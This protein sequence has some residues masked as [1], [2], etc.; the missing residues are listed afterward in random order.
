MKTVVTHLITFALW[1]QAITIPVV[2]AQGM[3]SGLSFNFNEQSAV[4]AEINSNISLDPTGED[5]YGD[6]SEEEMALLLATEQ[7]AQNRAD[8]DDGKGGIEVGIID[9]VRLIPVEGQADTYEE[10]P[11]KVDCNQVALL[12]YKLLEE[13]LGSDK[14]FECT[15]KNWYLDEQVKFAKELELP[16]EK[17]FCKENLSEAEK[18]RSLASKAMEC[19]GSVACNMLKTPV[20]E[21]IGFDPLADVVKWATQGS[22]FGKGCKDT[23]GN[24]CI[25]T[26]IWGIFK[27]LFTNIEGFWDLGKMLVNGVVE[28]AKWVGGKVVEAG[29][30]VAEKGAGIINWWGD[31]LFGSKP[32][33]EF[34]NRMASRHDVISQQEDG[35]FK[36]FLS[37]PLGT[38][39][40]LLSSLFTGMMDMIV[41]GTKDNF[42]CGGDWYTQKGDLRSANSAA[43]Y[44]SQENREYKSMG[45]RAMEDI[46]NFGGDVNAARHDKIRCDDPFIAECASCGQWMNMVC[47]LAGFLGGEVLTAVL[48]GGAV[49]VIGKGAK[50]ASTGGRLVTAALRSSNKW[51]EF[52]KLGKAAAAKTKGAAFKGLDNLK[53]V[54]KGGTE[55]LSKFSFNGM[56]S[57]LGKAGKEFVFSLGGK[58]IK[59]PGNAKNALLAALKKGREMGVKGM[60]KATLKAPFKVA[61]KT[62]KMGYVASKSYLKL[63]DDAFIYG[64]QGKKGLQIARMAKESNRIQKELKG[65]K[66][67]AEAGDEAAMAL[68]RAHQK[69]LAIL[70]EHQRLTR[71]A[72][73]ATDDATKTRLLEDAKAQAAKLD[74][75]VDEI[76]RAKGTF[77]AEQAERIR[78]ASQADE[79]GNTAMANAATNGG[80]A[81]NVAVNGSVADNAVSPG[82]NYGDFTE[83]AATTGMRNARTSGARTR[84]PATLTV[85]D[86]VKAN[87]KIRDRVKDLG[88][89]RGPN[90]SQM[91]DAQQSF[92]RGILNNIDDV[93]QREALIKKIADDGWDSVRRTCN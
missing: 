69:R 21:A 57:A 60:A 8:C 52:S 74:D 44:H 7:L 12:E 70:D 90:G 41:E 22:D 48:T 93:A 67:A 56:K 24:G 92:A 85:D 72:M 16:M 49:N 13:E 25:S 31:K 14:A 80:A 64:M 42:M 50:A 51:D 3:F 65:L 45:S 47:G 2:N 71:E 73:K 19:A 43:E 87:P 79:A 81:D 10:K 38:T 75:S 40:G 20:G 18:S 23:P 66:E 89:L 82:R 76:A 35:F 54:W 78:L 26:A 83:E 33:E 53:G 84:K 9:V 39:G 37:D 55:T 6:L 63:L 62:I 11:E 30:W 91:S 27:N 36:N 17:H 29:E 46:M 1:F 15:T 34:E 58:V 68:V 5:P 28:G 32:L 4:Q 77:D 88:T 61:G 86:V 59:L